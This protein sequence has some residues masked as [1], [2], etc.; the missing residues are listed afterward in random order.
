MQR[1]RLLLCGML[2]ALFADCATPTRPVGQDVGLDLVLSAASGG[3]GEVVTATATV[4]NLGETAIYHCEGCGCGVG[5][6]LGV[7]DPN[8]RPVGVVDPRSPHPT[9]ADDLMALLPKKQ[10]YAV[11]TFNGTLYDATGSPY[12]APPGKYT[13]IARFEYQRSAVPGDDVNVL[14]KQARLSW[15]TKGLPQGG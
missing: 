5:I 13:I 10:K 11:L 12:A 14:Q 4:S 2:V 3:P 6:D 8:G 1:I 9:C 15:D 7:L